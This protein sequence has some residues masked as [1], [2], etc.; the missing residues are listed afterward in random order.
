ME[1]LYK[2]L[3]EKNKEIQT[4]HKQG[5]EFYSHRHTVKA[6]VKMRW[7]YREV[8]A[9]YYE[10]VP[11]CAKVDERDRLNNKQLLKKMS[12]WNTKGY[13]EPE[14]VNS[15]IEKIKAAGGVQAEQKSITVFSEHK[16]GDFL[17]Y[18]KDW[19]GQYPTSDVTE[20]LKAHYDKLR[21]KMSLDGIMLE[22]KKE[23]EGV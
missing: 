9:F 4:T 16:I 18:Y 12:E 20:Q 11:D 22:W 21:D 3:A 13:I 17:R 8:V 23:H 19:K 6:L 1:D 2:K 10:S 5:M 15:E 7:R 14:R